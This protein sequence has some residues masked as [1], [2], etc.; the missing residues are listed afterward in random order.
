MKLTP[1]QRLE[2][3]YS[4]I[5]ASHSM[6]NFTLVRA[7]DAMAE[8]AFAMAC[9]EGTDAAK[10]AQEVASAAIARAGITAPPSP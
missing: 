9:A 8:L 4:R 1:A 2:L 10:R 3:L 5:E 6:L 7:S